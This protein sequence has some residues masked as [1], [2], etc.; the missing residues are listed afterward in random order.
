M[1]TEFPD[2]I[3]LMITNKSSC[4]NAR[5]I[6]PATYQVLARCV[7]GDGRGGGLPHLDLGPPPPPG[8]GYSPTWT[9][10][11][12]VLHQLD[13]V[14]PAWTWDPPVGWMGY[15]PLTGWGTPPPRPGAG[16]PLPPPRPGTGYPPPHGPG[17]GYPIPPTSSAGWGTP[18]SEM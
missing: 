9:W 12:V 7:C 5:G 16:Y 11:G 6:P 14:P 2:Q 8:M 17:M 4:A 3:K 15:P 18:S 1:K 13:R 10:D